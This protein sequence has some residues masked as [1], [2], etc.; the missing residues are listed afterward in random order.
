MTEKLQ[1]VVIKTIQVKKLILVLFWINFGFAQEQYPVFPQCDSLATN[2]D[3]IHC[4]NG[5]LDD[6]LQEALNKDTAL[7][8]YSNTL[9]ILF[10][11]TDKGSF[12]VL[13][14]DATRTNIDEQVKTLFQNFDTI[15]PA[16]YN[17]V[18]FS[19]QFNYRYVKQSNQQEVPTEAVTSQTELKPSEEAIHNDVKYIKPAQAMDYN[20]SFSH[21]N[22]N[23]FDASI[24]TIATPFFTDIKPYLAREVAQYYSLSQDSLA[25][26]TQTK[27]GAKLW[28]KHLVHIS[29]KDYWFTLDPLLDIRLGKNTNSANS[30]TYLNQR[31]VTVTGGLGAQFNFYADI[32]ESQG[33]FADYIN[34]YAYSMNPVGGYN[35]VVPGMGV[36]TE[37]KGNAFDFP[38]SEGYISYTP[39]H[40]FN[41]QFGQGKN[42]IGDGYRSLFL[43]DVASNYPYF[44]ISTQ[45]W[46]LKYTNIYL[47]LRD[48]RPEVN[49]DEYFEQKFMAL[50]NLSWQATP[51]L[52]LSFF[53]SVVFDN[54]RGRGFEVGY[55]NPIIFYKT[56]E[57]NM[58]SLHGNGAV[59][60][61]FKYKINNTMQVYGQ[62]LLDEF[63]LKDFIKSTGY[64]G[65]KYAIQLGGKY[66]NAFAI[67]GLNLQAEFDM[68]RP[69]TYSHAN[70]V[71]NYGHMNQSLAHPWGANFR[72][73]NLIT[74]YTQ[75]RWFAYAQLS[76]GEK[77]FD[78]DVTVSFGGDIYQSYDNHP[79]NYGNTTAQGN[80]ASIA[81]AQFN[82]GY[83][84]NPKTNLRAFASL[85]AR[86][87]TPKV[88]QV[89][90]VKRNTTW[91]QFGLRTDLGNWYFD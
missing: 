62:A 13:Y 29:G 66:F 69:Y 14:T 50:H 63:T 54:S 76:L 17:G 27:L 61:G 65:N 30:Y 77:G 83:L 39:S 33:R 78:N 55:F 16:K 82:L 89:D 42:F 25:R 4:F 35:A 87:F 26:E 7:A 75:K 18:A 24:N 46:K 52:T 64:W 38:V 1:Q 8:T 41:F 45:F 34:T 79:N 91:F 19:K 3:L 90:F 73:L 20:V 37:F 53:E 51:K 74:R 81:T 84:V 85:T 68:A 72:E 28:N 21:M 9:N 58:G 43:S 57:L 12:H 44:K 36:A 56:I 31:G 10:E 70:P 80:K 6:Y 2:Q 11:I 48:V 86:S 47:W 40:F 32:R 67:Q 59:G 49:V 5:T 71:L 23:R 22:Y 60:L 15:I 88:P